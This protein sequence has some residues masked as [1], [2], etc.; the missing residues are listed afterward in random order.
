V[1]A[2]FFLLSAAARR[3]SDHHVAWLTTDVAIKI[4]ESL[5]LFGFFV[6]VIRE[7]F[8]GQQRRGDKDSGTIAEVLKLQTAAN[9]QASD[10][11]A[12]LAHTML[13]ALNNNTTVLE[14]VCQQGVTN[15]TEWDRHVEQVADLGDRVE[16][17][18]VML[19]RVDQRTLRLEGTQEKHGLVLGRIEKKLGAE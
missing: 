13:A 19:N 6:L 18:E 7:I 16:H 9:G 4:I 5:G 1:Q 12:E 17:N 8:A 3:G 14:R 15:Q 10:R 2:G 11:Y